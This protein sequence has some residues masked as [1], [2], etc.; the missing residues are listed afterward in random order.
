MK[1]L[2]RSFALVLA[3]VGSVLVCPAARSQ[4]VLYTFDG[5]SPQDQFSWS[6]SGAGDVNG[7][8]FDDLI[9]GAPGDDNNGAGSGSA[10]VFSGVDGSVLYTFDG[11]SGGDR[12]GGSVSGAGDVNGDGFDDLIVGA[13]LDDNNGPDSGSARVFA[14]R[15]PLGTSY[16]GPAVANSTG[17]PGVIRSLGLVGATANEAFLTAYQLSH[18]TSAQPLLGYFLVSRT[19]GS[20][21]PPGS[22]GL[23]CLGGDI[24]RYNQPSNVGEGPTFSIQVDLTSMPVNPPQA[25]LPGETWN[26]QAW[27]M[28]A[29]GTNNFTDA[30]SVLFQ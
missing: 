29:G 6:V 19:Q 27:Y 3:I 12:F 24:G 14:S 1:V 15:G 7:D 28:D 20:F 16:C 9:V 18:S 5:D 21:M 30:V 23:V 26:F 13:A 17:Q 22:Q 25:V 2:A 11:D 10:R 8:G 4:S